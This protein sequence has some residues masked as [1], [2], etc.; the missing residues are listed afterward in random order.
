MWG[1]VYCNPP[2]DRVSSTKALDGPQCRMLNLRIGYV[3]C[4][5]ISNSHVDFK[6]V[7][8][9]MSN[10][11]NGLCNVD[12]FFFMLIGSM[13]HVAFGK[14]PYACRPVEFKGQG[15]YQ[16]WKIDLTIITT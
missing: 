8:C 1:N 16:Y 11:R 2:Q 4:H 9:R 5:Y 10:L 6:M 7:S 13:S 14:W 15:P 3:D 12:D